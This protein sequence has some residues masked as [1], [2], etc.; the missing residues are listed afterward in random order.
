VETKVAALDLGADDYMTKPFNTKELFAR[1]R[2]LLRKRKAERLSENFLRLNDLTLYLDRHEVQIGHQF[3][4]LTKK[5]FELLTYLIRN[6]NIALT[7][8]RILQSVWGYDYAGDTNVVDVYIRYLRVKIDNKVQRK[9]IH[10]IRGLG[11][12]AKD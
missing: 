6:K 9:Y 2:V 10:T 1:I 7:R 3:I 8:D 11:Y 12:T 5:E 4:E